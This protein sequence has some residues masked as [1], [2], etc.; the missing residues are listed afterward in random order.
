MLKYIVAYI[1]AAVV[2]VAVDFVWLAFIAQK[3]YQREIGR[4]LLDKPLLSAAVPFYLLYLVGAVWF[5]TRAG[6]EAG[7]WSVALLNGALFG[8]IAYA[9]YDL[10]N[11]ATLKGFSWTV[12]AADLFWG[13]F[14]TATVAT[15]GYFAAGFVKG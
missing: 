4:L 7:S 8:F 9:T 10:T 11:M 1:A 13:A 6:L 3:L 12:V 2:F 14:I 15:A 5:G